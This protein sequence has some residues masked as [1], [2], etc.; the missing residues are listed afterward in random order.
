MKNIRI[1]NDIRVVLTVT[2][3]GHAEDLRGKRLV[4][5]LRSKKTSVE[6]QDFEVHG[7]QVTFTWHGSEQQVTGPYYITLY[8]RQGQRQN[9]EDTPYVFNLVATSHMEDEDDEYENGCGCVRTDKINVGVNL[10]PWGDSPELR[11]Y[12]NLR[13]LPRINDIEL[14]GNVSLHEL[15]VVGWEELKRHWPTI[16]GKLLHGELTPERLGMVGREEFEE[17]K[18]SINGVELKGELTA[19]ELGLQ[20]EGDYVTKKCLEKALKEIGRHGAHRE[21]RKDEIDMI[22]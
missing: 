12:R 14:K 9:V 10:G 15:G 18:A 21:V 13:H 7:N 5:M 1:G 4:V 3:R 6:I 22:F 11:D 17:S 16:K 8:E 20:P 19:E 2:R